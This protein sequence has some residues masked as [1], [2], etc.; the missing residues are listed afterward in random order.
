MVNGECVWCRRVWFLQITKSN[1]PHIKGETV[2]DRKY[3]NK[4]MTNDSR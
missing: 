1:D 3:L 4:Y 2:R